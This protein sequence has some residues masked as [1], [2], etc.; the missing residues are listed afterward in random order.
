M[1]IAVASFQHET[2]TF[3]PQK[4]QYSDFVLS[5]GWPGMLLGQKVIN[6]LEGLNIAAAGFIDAAK[7]HH[8]LL[9]VNWCSAEPAGKVSREAFNQ[10]TTEMQQALRGFGVFDALYLDLHGAMVSDDYPDG[11]LEIVRRMR[12][13]VGDELMIVCSLDFHANLSREFIDSID[14]M[15]LYRSYPHLDMAETGVRCYELLEAYFDK[16][17]LCR[18]FIQIPYL[19]PLSS[20]HTGSEPNT[21][22]FSRLAEFEQDHVISNIEFAMG[23]P[24]ADIRDSGASVCVFG[25]DQERVDHICQQFYDCILAVESSFNDPLITAHA[26]WQLA[27]SNRHQKPIVAGDVQDNPG[28]GGSGDTTGVLADLIQAR[29]QKTIIAVL[30]D[31][32]A[33]SVA[34]QVG[35]GTEVTLSLGGRSGVKALGSYQAKYRVNALG[36]GN[37]TCTGVMYAGCTVSLGSMALLQVVDE[38]AD[39]QIIVSSLRYACTDLAV[40]GHLGLDP[41]DAKLLVVKSTQHFRAAFEDICQS[42]VLVKSPGLHPCQLSE[43]TY[44]H[45]RSNVRLGPSGPVHHA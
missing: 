42:V 7:A 18:A 5:D 15:A 40:Y 9:P 14:A 20:Q 24:A 4:T 1:R 8:E 19:I 31:P 22:L 44:Q 13:V 37:F 34:H 29:A 11:E 23:F 45:L 38:H 17:K 39:V 43:V 32:E 10:I 21:T 2:N 28:A 33:V 16:P 12:E 30:A 6:Q 35:V 3:S 25:V 36:S 27:A 41:L 26:A